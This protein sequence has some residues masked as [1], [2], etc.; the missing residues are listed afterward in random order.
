MRWK[1]FAAAIFGLWLLF[2]AS[3]KWLIASIHHDPRYAEAGVSDPIA[4]SI[5]FRA[6]IVVTIL[7][8]IAWLAYLNKKIIREL[9]EE[10]LLLIVATSG[11]SL[12]IIFT[13]FYQGRE[14]YPLMPLIEH[15]EA[16][17]IVGHRLLFVW[18]AELVHH[19]F[20]SLGTKIL[21]IASQVPAA[22]FTSLM[23]G[24]WSAVFI[25]KRLAFVGQFLSLVFLLPTISYYNFYDIGIVGFYAATFLAVFRRRLWLTIPLIAAATLNHEN[26][27]LLVPAVGF[28]AAAMFPMRKVIFVT[29]A[30]LAAHFG[31]RA[32]FWA[33]MP[34]SH[35]GDIRFFSNAV[36]IAHLS[37]PL[38]IG[39]CI[40]SMRWVFALMGWKYAPLELKRLAVFWPLL[41]AVTLAFGQVTETRQFDADIPFCVA[42]TLVFL[43]HAFAVIE[44][45]IDLSPSLSMPLPSECLLRQSKR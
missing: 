6:M 14:V 24:L 9:A 33:L 18:P 28:A 41:V 21:F 32:I 39:G 19:W 4:R 43:K 37:P 20:P 11:C 13:L 17:A 44:P 10:Y 16:Q 30:A 23:I 27:L 36:W 29:M 40:L 15:P 45:V 1:Q 35:S 38:L 3:V 12:L 7:A 25:G 31:I 34:M 2:L 26:A 42:L 8:L 5:F 22:I